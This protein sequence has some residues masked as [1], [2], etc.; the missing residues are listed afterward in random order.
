MDAIS[1]QNK[2]KIEDLLEQDPLV[3]ETYRFETKNPEEQTSSTLL[4]F[5]LP[6]V[7]L[8]LDIQCVSYRSHSTLNVFLI[9]GL[10]WNRFAGDEISSIPHKSYVCTTH[11]S[12]I[13]DKIFY[14]KKY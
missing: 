4:N 2:M 14:L 11:G 1:I 12:F 3:H 10:F 9:V 13:T 5:V 8:F 6:K 7:V